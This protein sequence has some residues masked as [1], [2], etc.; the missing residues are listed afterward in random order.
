MTN[1]AKNSREHLETW[2]YIDDM[3]LQ[4]GS[5]GNNILDIIIWS[6]LEI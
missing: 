2:N 6:V 3:P 4:A 5:Q 1:N